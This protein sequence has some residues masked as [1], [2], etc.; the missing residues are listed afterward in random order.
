MLQFWLRFIHSTSRS[1]YLD[2]PNEQRRLW[3]CTL[4]EFLADQDFGDRPF[5]ASGNAPAAG[6]R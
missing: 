2:V 5:L 6:W 4:A 3:S 1:H